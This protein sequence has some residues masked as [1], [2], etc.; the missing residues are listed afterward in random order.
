MP[1]RVAHS[2]CASSIEAAHGHILD[3]P[4]PQWA[5]GP[6]R[7]IGGHRGSS[8]ELKVAGPSML[9]I[10]RPGRHALPRI[11]SSKMRRPRRVLPS[12]ASGFVLR[13][14]GVIECEADDALL[15]TV[16]D[17]PLAQASERSP[18][19]YSGAGYAQ[20]CPRRKPGELGQRA[21]RMPLTETGR[22]VWV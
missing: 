11:T 6:P 17:G 12:R 1:G 8:P 10:G 16:A 22:R 13:R 5:N 9:G 20:P 3:H 2:R 21:A 18:F 4:R 14:E 7:S 19:Y 15:S